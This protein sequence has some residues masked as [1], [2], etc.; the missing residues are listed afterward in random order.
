MGRQTNKNKVFKE[1]SIS[2]T[3]VS[4]YMPPTSENDVDVDVDV[5][6]DA[7]RWEREHFKRLEQEIESKLSDI[8]SNTDVKDIIKMVTYT[9]NMFT[10]TRIDTIRILYKLREKVKQ[11]DNQHKIQ[12][13]INHFCYEV[14][15]TIV[16]KP[17][18]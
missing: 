1:P 18:H 7:P 6:V 9:Y 11:E 3:L 14:D 12:K 8:P 4:K 5:D 13:V 15:E 17:P 16:L 2:I 10:D